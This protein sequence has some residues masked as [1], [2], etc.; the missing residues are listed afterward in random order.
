MAN[1]IT[2]TIVG[3]IGKVADKFFP[4]AKDA[5]AFKLALQKES[6]EGAMAELNR[7]YD[8]II[9]EANSTDK[10]T[11]RARPSF[12][13]VMYCIILASIPMGILTAFNPLAATNIITGFKAW[14]GAIP[15]SMWALFGTGYVGYSVSRSY[16]KHMEKKYGK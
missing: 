13:Y 14:L 5:Q 2:D 15:D 6:D 4:D 3:I 9:A 16:D 12:M 11:S 8:A 10:W 1:P 7:S